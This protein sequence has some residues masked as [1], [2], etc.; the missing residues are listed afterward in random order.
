[1]RAKLSVVR[2]QSHY[3]LRSS[4]HCVMVTNVMCMI[5]TVD[6]EVDDAVWVVHDNFRMN[7]RYGRY[8]AAYNMVG[9][10]LF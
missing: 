3:K 6:D 7:T 5:S 10:L 2:F 8:G 4:L 9:L 1:M